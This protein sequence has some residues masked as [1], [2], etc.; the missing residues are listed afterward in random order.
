MEDFAQCGMEK[1]WV[2]KQLKDLGRTQAELAKFM[3][4][5]ETKL[6]KMLGAQY[7]RELR[8]K[9][10]DLIRAFL[11][12]DTDRHAK[13]HGSSTVRPT[14]GPITVPTNTD[15]SPPILIYRTALTGV[16][17]GGDFTMSVA[18]VALEVQ[19]PG[20]LAD[21]TDVFGLFVLGDS[22]SPKYVSGELI[23]YEEGPPPKN[24]DH[25][26]VKMKPSPDGTQELYLK[27]LVRWNAFQ[28]TV[29]QY[30]PDKTFDIP[31][32]DVADVVRV[33]TVA[34]LVEK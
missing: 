18:E 8:D 31:M 17:G 11:R 20:K 33:L 34:D 5:S 23:L 12:P 7:K 32:T 1:A 22:M 27:Q 2:K 15:R 6:S 30:N 10:A 29:R 19:R 4:V 28:I 3:E 26:V 14:D 16:T 21:R 9:E 24:L 25:I 13:M